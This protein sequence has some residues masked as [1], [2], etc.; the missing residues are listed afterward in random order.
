MPSVNSGKRTI[1]KIKVSKKNISLIFSQGE[2]IQI[3]QNAYLST[4]LYEGKTLSDKEVNQ[5][6]ELTSLSS[7]LN[8]AF[9]VVSKRRLSEQ[10]MYEKLIKKKDNVEAAN[11]VI[12]KLKA[13]NLL[14]DKAYMKSLVAFDNERNYGK[15]KML[16][17]LK[18]QGIPDIMVNEI[19]FSTDV[20][21]KKAKVLLPSLEKKY[22]RLSFENKRRHIYSTL[23]ARGFSS[24]IA[25]NTINDI[26]RGSKEEEKEKLAIDYQ[27]IKTRFK[28][29]Y[30]G[31]Q[32]KQ[33]I[34]GAL[35]NKGYQYQDIKEILGDDQNENDC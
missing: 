13:S 2:K 34:Y 10:Q 7:L 31:Y 3:S 24:E 26:K 5:L 12:A 14:D 30:D 27:T 23:L 32:L 33:K 28:R 20:E 19:S 18:E 22:E 25:R 11:N 4:F 17:H 15:N 35:V 8:Y 21:E 6:V 9:N 29:K 1:K 16:K